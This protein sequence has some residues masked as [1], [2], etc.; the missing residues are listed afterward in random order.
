MMIILANRRRVI[1]PLTT[2]GSPQPST[3][4]GLILPD[5][6]PAV[7]S[8]SDEAD[9]QDASN[10]FL[11]WYHCDCQHLSRRAVCAGGSRRRM[12]PKSE[13]R[14]LAII[15]RTCKS[16]VRHWTFTFVTKSCHWMPR[17]QCRH[18]MWNACSRRLFSASNVQ[19]SDPWSS[20]G[21]T[22]IE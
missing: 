21:R 1:K 12:W 13:W 16:L 5:P 2:F 9:R 7:R 18:V 14:L 4:P 8:T 17:M 3:T 20:T 22:I 6:P 11:A 19:V 10:H 15:S